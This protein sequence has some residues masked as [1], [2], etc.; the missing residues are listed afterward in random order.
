[1]TQVRR[2]RYVRHEVGRNQRERQTDALVIRREALAEEAR[3][4]IL[5]RGYGTRRH[6]YRLG[7]RILL[8]HE[9]RRK[10]E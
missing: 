2:G 8:F 6:Q 4:D 9:E 3:F 7:R 1:M 5:A 10:G